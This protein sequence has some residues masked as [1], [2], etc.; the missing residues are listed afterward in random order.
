MKKHFG[1]K[2]KLKDV[3]YHH[4]EDY[5]DYLKNKHSRMVRSFQF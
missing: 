3:T 5:Y 4:I 2:L 1:N